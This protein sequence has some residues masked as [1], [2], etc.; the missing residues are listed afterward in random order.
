MPPQKENMKKLKSWVSVL[1]VLAAGT[2]VG[3]STTATKAADVSGSIRAS[4][5]QAGLKGIRTSQDRDKGVVTLGGH[6]ATD[7]GKLQAAS[8][9]KSIAMDQVVSNEI[10]VI[11]PGAGSDR[12]MLTSDLDMR[13]ESNLDA[14]LINDRRH[15]SV[16]YSVRNHVVTLTGNVESQSLRARAEAVATAVLHVQRV[17]NDLQV[18]GQKA[19]SSKLRASVTL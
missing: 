2:L 7:A 15:D 10:A 5:E 6:V 1:A 16:K 14:A 18:K 8:I 12:R 13:I 4:L 19:T 11:A 17:V 9:A 3:C